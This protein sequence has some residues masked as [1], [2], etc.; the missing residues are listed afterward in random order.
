MS[1]DREEQKPSSRG[2]LVR[3]CKTHPIIVLQPEPEFA[4]D[5]QESSARHSLSRATRTHQIIVLETEDAS[6]VP[7]P[8]LPQGPQAPSEGAPEQP[9]VKP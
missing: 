4:V 7:P 1:N 8:A 6:P 9:S 5:P 3:S 2:A